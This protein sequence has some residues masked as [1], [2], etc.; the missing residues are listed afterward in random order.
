MQ[1]YYLITY[2]T[3]KVLCYPTLYVKLFYLAKQFK[4]QFPELLILIKESKVTKIRPEQKKRQ[5]ITPAL[6]LVN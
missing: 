5:G 6:R 2:T 3:Y 1:R 4:Q